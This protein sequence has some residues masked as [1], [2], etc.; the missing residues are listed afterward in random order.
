[1]YL[2]T[3]GT[4]QGSLNSAATTPAATINSIS[5]E[6]KKHKEETELMKITESQIR[7]IIREELQSQ[8]L[9]ERGDEYETTGDQQPPPAVPPAS[10]PQ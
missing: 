8:A 4:A 10:Q 9:Q 5:I 2:C 6:N 7:Q 1:M 3:R